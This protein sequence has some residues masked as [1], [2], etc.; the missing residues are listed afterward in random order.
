MIVQI[1]A[2]DQIE[3]VGLVHDSD[4]DAVGRRGLVAFRW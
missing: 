3:R 2:L 4:R 1:A